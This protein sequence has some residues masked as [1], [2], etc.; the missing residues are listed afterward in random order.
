MNT[1]DKNGAKQTQSRREFL[2]SIS[3]TMAGALILSGC[4]ESGD[5]TDSDKPSYY[6]PRPGITNPYVS[7]NGNPLLVCVEGT[8]FATMLDAGFAAIGG[9][10][11]LINQNQDVLI[12]PNLFERSEY[13]WISS[14]D[15][16]VS[17]I[18]K[19]QT[20]S[21]GIVNVGD[22]SFEDTASV[23][24]HLNLM[25]TINAA[26]GILLNF[27][28]THKV[29]RDTWPSS[30]PDFAVFSAVY[31]APIL[32]NTP[33]LKRHYLSRLTCAIKCNVGT[34][35]GSQATDTREYMHFR[36]PN[37]L[38]ELAE[39]AGVSNPDLNI[40]DARSIVTVNGPF[41]EQ[42]GNVVN[43]NKVIIC[44]DI[45]AT[46]VYCAKLMA[47]NDPGFTLA[48]IQTTID[49]AVSLGLGTADLNRVEIIEVNT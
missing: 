19:V 2:K 5:G 48:D 11:K 27:R 17:I 24:E 26:G 18:K 34:I 47:E 40:V 38:A 12:K 28:E 22:M 20:V 1:Q 23:Y 41:Y 32:I 13:P 15:S 37:F 3:S 36:S 21:T 14:P 10:N 44:G 6:G 9:L 45:V 49:R 46:D 42:G 29:R 7:G 33:V 43:T 8:D 4:N 16:I 39:V 31:D 35:S 30:K 25:P